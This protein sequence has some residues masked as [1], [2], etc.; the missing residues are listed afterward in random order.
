MRLDL[1]LKWSRLVLRRT[2]AKELCDA[3][4][5][6]VNGVNARAGREVRVGD[7]LEIHLLRRRIKARIRAIPAHAP[8][9]EGS[10]EMVELIEDRRDNPDAE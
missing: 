1:F 9:K 8:G 5:V 10:R 2:M 6:S 3:D 7:T 4:R